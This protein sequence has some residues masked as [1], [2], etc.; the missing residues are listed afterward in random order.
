M[1]GEDCFRW[2][3]AKEGCDNRTLRQVNIE[4][5]FR[6]GKVLC[7]HSVNGA[8]YSLDGALYLASE[9]GAMHS[10][11]GADRIRPHE[12]IEIENCE[13]ISEPLLYEQKE[14]TSGRRST[15]ER[16]SGLC[17]QGR[18]LYP[19]KNLKSKKILFV[20]I[21][22]SDFKLFYKCLYSFNFLLDAMPHQLKSKKQQETK[23][24]SSK[25]SNS[26]LDVSLTKQ[27]DKQRKPS[28]SASSLLELS[29]MSLKDG[30]K[31]VEMK[32]VEN[33]NDP[34]LSK[35]NIEKFNLLNST[36][37]DGNVINKYL[38]QLEKSIDEVD[39]EDM[40][41]LEI[42]DHLEDEEINPYEGIF[43]EKFN[44]ETNEVILQPV[45]VE[46]IV[47]STSAKGNSVKGENKN[48]L[49]LKSTEKLILAEKRKMETNQVVG[50]E[51]KVAC[52]VAVDYPK[53]VINE[54][55]K[56]KITNRLHDIVNAR[57]AKIDRFEDKLRF[58]KTDH[59]AGVVIIT[60]N[61]GKT[62]NFIRLA[63]EKVHGMKI[64]E[65][66][67]IKC[68][69]LR[70]VKFAPTFQL[71]YPD[72][73]TAFE[74][75]QREIREQTGLETNDWVF[76]DNA[77]RNNGGGT[78]CFFIGNLELVELAAKD[79]YKEV[80][81]QFGV[82]KHVIMKYLSNEYEQGK[83]TKQFSQ[84]VKRVNNKISVFKAQLD[85]KQLR[86]KRN[87][88]NWQER[89]KRASWLRLLRCRWN[90]LEGMK[91][92]CGNSESLKGYNT[93]MNNELLMSSHMP[94]I[95]SNVNYISPS[96]NRSQ[97]FCEKIY[98]DPRG[99]RP[100]TLLNLKCYNPIMKNWVSDSYKSRC[101]KNV[102]ENKEGLYRNEPKQ[103]SLSRKE[104]T[105]TQNSRHKSLSFQGQLS[106][107]LLSGY[108]CRC[109]WKSPAIGSVDGRLG[110]E[111]RSTSIMESNNG[112]KLRKI[113][114]RFATG[115]FLVADERAC[116][117]W[118]CMFWG[119]ASRLQSGHSIGL[120]AARW[121]PSQLHE[122]PV[123]GILE[124]ANHKSKGFFK[125]NRYSYDISK[126][127]EARKNQCY[128][129]KNN[130]NRIFDVS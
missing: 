74:E 8:M 89:R 125:H 85:P 73:N 81:R 119:L 29:N 129:N 104:I 35:G 84:V 107:R 41:D 72:P 114:E 76:I 105:W 92:T 77:K 118:G 99:V 123:C 62:A 10:F 12:G 61:K 69:P 96:D 23:Q 110:V 117:V 6:K 25:R 18:P 20:E 30:E 63:T 36:I 47:P 2:K 50:D 26:E 127:F 94:R 42:A 3:L 71:F 5:K 1:G 44:T 59:K 113:K 128:L 19:S 97:S 87:L 51:L 22:V 49:D 79:R 28:G 68:L 83:L 126:N 112:T 78:R 56:E 46:P 43:P 64:D 101:K 11:G 16:R 14:R 34:M 91:Q 109:Q 67:P 60:C 116:H 120:L 108:V 53:I 13:I 124:H 33:E 75:M 70:E 38:E 66:P 17:K 90:N 52:I 24:Q 106:P 4:E 86:R 98:F 9:A 102:K 100:Q 21:I 103:L 58:L 15:Y 82:A 27:R 95:F 121:R 55:S 48:V 32:Q 39:T 111:W 93:I 31:D 122:P 37:A 57:N 130:Q 80:R 115:D 65:I 88:Q 45:K 54:K 40:P 7:L